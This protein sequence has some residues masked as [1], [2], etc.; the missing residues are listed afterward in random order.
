MTSAA[1][2]LS[3]VL[4]PDAEGPGPAA[5]L[6]RRLKTFAG[7]KLRKKPGFLIIGAQKAGT[8]SLHHYLGRHPDLQ[9][10]NGPK[11]LHFFN[12]YHDRGMG[13]YMSHFPRRV[14]RDRRTWFEATPDYLHQPMAAERIRR[15]LGPVRLVAILREPAAR[16]HSAWK[17]WSRFDALRPEESG[18]ADRRSFADAISEELDAPDG[19]ADRHYHYVSAGRYAEHLARF[20]DHF[21]RE[22]ILILDHAQMNADLGGFLDRICSFLGV[23][24]FPDDDIARFGEKRLWTSPA[25]EEEDD[26]QATLQRL[27]DYYAPW[28]ERLF[29]LIGERWAW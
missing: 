28:N 10:A 14:P 25:V 29:G 4:R 19:S 23:D 5:H 24:P 16:A 2:A 9:S 1:N 12:L 21:P 15:D 13:W 26:T 17:M 20:L 18:K 11:E 3:R 6:T 22:R 8:T 27:R 7:P